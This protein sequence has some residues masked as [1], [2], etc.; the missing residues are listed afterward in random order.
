MGTALV[1]ANVPQDPT[2]LPHDPQTTFRSWILESD[3]EW[4]SPTLCE[5]V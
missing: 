4:M 2:E 5:K 1:A 3:D